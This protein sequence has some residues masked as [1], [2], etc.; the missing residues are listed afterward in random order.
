M[1]QGAVIALFIGYRFRHALATDPAP[2][3]PWVLGCYGALAS[4][5]PWTL[6]GVERGDFEVPKSIALGVIFALPMFVAS[7]WLGESPYHRL[8][9]AYLMLSGLWVLHLLAAVGLRQK[10]PPT[11]P[12]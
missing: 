6:G 1:L 5:L 11:N 12:A 4:T 9:T 3:W 10:A 2:L 7:R 8:G